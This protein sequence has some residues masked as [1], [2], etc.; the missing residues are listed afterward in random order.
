MFTT[1]G[2]STGFTARPEAYASCT[3]TCSRPLTIWYHDHAMG[4][5]RLNVVAGL[6][7]FFL[8]R[9]DV[10]DSLNLPKGVGKY[11]IPLVIQDRIFNPDGS[12]FYPDT[13]VTPVHP[14]W[15]PEFFGDVALVNGK[16]WPYLSVEPR[17]YRLRF[18][19]GSEACFYVLTLSS[20]PAVLPDRHGRRFA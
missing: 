13:G 5:T 4:I 12:L 3:P 2:L 8:I 7:G 1:A 10:E 19:N 18:L 14:K 16:V 9:D 20:G 15:V 17:K 11:E 6:A